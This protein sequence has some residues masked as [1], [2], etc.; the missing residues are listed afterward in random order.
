MSVDTVQQTV[1]EVAKSTSFLSPMW[2]LVLGVTTIIVLGEIWIRNTRQYKVSYSIP[3]PP[4]LPIL[5]QGHLVIGLSN[6]GE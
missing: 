1:V 4:R 2:T 5:G 3:C 6:S